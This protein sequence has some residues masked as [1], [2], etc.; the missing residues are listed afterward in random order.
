M[1][2]DVHM[3][4]Q[5]QEA[6]FPRNYPVFPS[7]AAPEASRLKIAHRYVAASTLG[8]DFFDVIQLSDTTCGVLVCDVMGH[9]VRAGLLTALIRGVV[10]E[11]GEWSDDPAHVLGEIN[12]GL[13]PIVHQTGQPVFATAF[14]G[15]IDSAAGKITYSNGGHPPPFLLQRATGSLARLALVNPEPAAGLMEGFTYSSQVV[16]FP[17]GSLLL[18][19]TDG[20]IE[21]SDPSGQMFGEESLQQLIQQN[22]RP[23]RIGPARPA[24]QA[25][26]GLHRKE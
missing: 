18:G 16:E 22:P 1:E 10:E 6:F 2:A 24:R 19:Y 3:A 12:R 4:R 14:Y 5:I 13:M 9:G 15:V 23:I 20:L 7:G 25:G 11:V 8:G 21:A 17:P 26:Q